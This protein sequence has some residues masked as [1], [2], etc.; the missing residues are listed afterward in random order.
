[1][2]KKVLITGA[3][4]GLGKV[5]A[6]TLAS[7]GYDV[8]INYNKSKEAAQDLSKYLE[9]KYNAKT[10]LYQCDVSDEFGVIHMTK[11]IR[12]HIGDIDCIIHNA[13]ISKDNYYVDKTYSEFMDVVKNNLGGTFLICK[14]ASCLMKKGIIINISSTDSTTTYSP[15]SMDYCASKAGVNSLCKTFSMAL[16]NIKVIG[17]LLPWINT[18]SVLE[19]DKK[20]LDSELKRTGQKKLLDKFEVAKKIGELAN[21]SDEFD[22]GSIIE[23]DSDY[24]W[25]LK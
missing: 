14:F 2:N 18:E 25:I 6:E 15:I 21:N 24:K 23:M 8:I 9:E 12:T 7:I 10:Y 5:L 22:S 20:Y 16:K 4:R 1:M 13:A 11:Y 19:M 17:I 3:S